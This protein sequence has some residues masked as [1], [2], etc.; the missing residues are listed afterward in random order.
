VYVGSVG[1]DVTTPDD[2][3]TPFA[4]CRSEPGRR[5]IV[6]NDDVPVDDHLAELGRAGGEDALVERAI[7]AAELVCHA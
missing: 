7:R 1:A 5:R 6:E 2:A 3:R 4:Q